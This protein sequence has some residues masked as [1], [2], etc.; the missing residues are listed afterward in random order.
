VLDFATDSGDI[1]RLV[2]DYA[3]KVDAKATVEAIDRQ[4]S[5]LEIARSLS[6]NYPE[7]VSAA[8]R[9]GSSRK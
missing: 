4:S 6:A 7:I 9:S 1:S 3:R 5:T 2:I 8:R